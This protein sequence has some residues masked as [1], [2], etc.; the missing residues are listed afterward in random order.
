MSKQKNSGIFKLENGYWG[1]RFIITVDGKRKAQKRV[2]DEF[3]NPFKTEKQA[4]KA[5]EKAIIMEKTRM[6]LP[7]QKKIVRKTIGEVYKEY[8]EKGRNGKAFATKKKQDSLWNNYL[9][10]RFGGRY[11]DDI[12]VAEVNDYL[13]EL[14]CVYN[15]AYGYVEA[16][17]K[18]F[19]LIF[20]QAYSRNYMNVDDYNKLCVNKNGRISMP[21][22]KSTEVKDIVSYTKEEIKVMDSYFKGKTVETAYMI[23]KYAGLRSSE[24][25]G[26][27]WDCIDFEDGVI[28]VEKQMKTQ[29]GVV[30]LLPLKTVNA[31]RKV[32]MPEALKQYLLDLH[33]KRKEYE[34]LYSEQREQN[35]MFIMNIDERKISSLELVNTQPNGRIQTEWAIK[36][37]SRPLREQYNIQFKFHNLRHTYGTNLALMNTPAHILSNQ[38]GHSKSST[39][40]KYYLAISQEGIET[41]KD[42]L[43]KF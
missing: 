10:D 11:V 6:M 4:T 23:G 15:L 27:T 20:G 9:L 24:C 31:K 22:K 19:Y 18:Q 30:K 29:E 25:Y 34:T 14:Y 39:T 41:L 2:R 42:N 35:E 38:M 33:E 5:R 32:F 21:S 8:C 43:N 36:H 37:H 40:H 7:P 16:F 13:A 28:L 1:Y 17:L 3:G 26:L 12:S